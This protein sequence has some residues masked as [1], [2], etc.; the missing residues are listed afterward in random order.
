MVYPQGTSSPRVS[1]R[2]ES[3]GISVTPRLWLVVVVS[4]FPAFFL[5]TL[6]ALYA[7]IECTSSLSNHVADSVIEN[8]V[9]ERVKDIEEK[10][11]ARQRSEIEQQVEER[12]KLVEARYAAE[13]MVPDCPANGTESVD[14]FPKE[15]FGHTIVDMARVDKEEFI[16][17]VDPGVPVDRSQSGASEV[18]LLYSRVNARPKRY[19]DKGFGSQNPKI[20]M[21]EAL[22]NCEQVNVIL[23]DHSGQRR[24]CFAIVPQYES[25]HIQKWMRIDEQKRG[26]LDDSKDLQLVSRGHQKE[27]RDEF[28]PPSAQDVEKAWDLLQHFF[29]SLDDVKRELDLLLKRIVKDNTVI[30]MVCN[31]GQSE[32]LLNFACSAR[33]RG[34][35]LSNILVFATDRE[36]LELSVGIGL[37]AYFDERVS[38]I[39]SVIALP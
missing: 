32:L 17:V 5:G 16:K 20:A 22:E 4:A 35:D 28:Y 29:E 10:F 12:V 13:Q 9:K 27:G 21:P 34:F 15:Q 7:G 23:A 38:A 2:P 6:S 18:L 30:I 31:F 24:Q 33:Q 39:V 36:T 37:N 25:Y 11:K 19:I 14:L 3:G 1:R 8:R 26:K